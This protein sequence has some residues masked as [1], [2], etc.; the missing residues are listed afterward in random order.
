[1]FVENTKN[2]LYLFF[3]VPIL[4]VVSLFCGLAIRD[5]G[6]VGVGGFL[7]LV[8]SL[9]VG[10]LVY[11]KFANIKSGN[12]FSFGIQSISASR[13]WAYKSSFHLLAIFYFVSVVLISGFGSQ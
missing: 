5:T 9:I 1:M 11:S 2:M 4:M 3:M 10:L 12:L 8:S 13:K 7:V 6:W